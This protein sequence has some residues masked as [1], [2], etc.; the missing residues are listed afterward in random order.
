MILSRG[1]SITVVD[2]SFGNTVDD[3]F[4]INVLLHHERQTRVIRPR[5]D[6][7]D[8]MTNTRVQET[9]P[10]QVTCFFFSLTL[11]LNVY[12]IRSVTLF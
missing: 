8:T 7:R 1:Y 11:I 6:P 3:F 4:D 10:I 2:V 12:E 9:L 5:T